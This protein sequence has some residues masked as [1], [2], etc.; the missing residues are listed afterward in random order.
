MRPL[1][2]FGYSSGVI[3]SLFLEVNLTVTPVFSVS[4]LIFHRFH[5]YF[6]IDF[7]ASW[8]FFEVVNGLAPVYHIVSIILC[9]LTYL[10]V[11]CGVPSECPQNC[12][13][14][15]GKCCFYYFLPPG[16]GAFV[17]RR[18]TYCCNFAFKK[19]CQC[20]VVLLFSFCITFLLVNINTL[21]TSFMYPLNLFV[22]VAILM[23]KGTSYFP[24]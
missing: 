1:L 21:F 24:Q 12:Q 16:Y 5:A 17:Y 23:L 3:Q 9:L 14:G 18:Q 22:V 8:C 7:Q 20:S 19:T 2:L 15:N 11:L 4:G 13:E 10:E 6:R